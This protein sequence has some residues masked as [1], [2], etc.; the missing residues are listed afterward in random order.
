MT[1]LT[2]ED[3]IYSMFSHIWECEIDHPIF[4]DTV[5][6]LMTAVIQCYH[7]HHDIIWTFCSDRNPDIDM[8]YPHHDDYLVKYESGDYDIAA[9]SNCNR[10]WSGQITEPYWNH[11]PYAKVVAWTPIPEFSGGD[12]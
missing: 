1:K 2:F 4:Q 9:Y 10:F 8:T 6:E 3:E 7:K 12:K 11:A 5:G